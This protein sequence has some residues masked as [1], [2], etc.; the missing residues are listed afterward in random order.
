MSKFELTRNRYF[1]AEK[2][3]LES[4][5]SYRGICDGTTMEIWGC[6]SGHALVSWN[7]EPVHLAA[8]RYTLIPAALGQFSVTAAE[9][10]L[11]LRVYLPSEKP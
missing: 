9:P 11:C 8:I 10:S 1:V 3:E 2:V 4:G 6:M 5:A 7:G